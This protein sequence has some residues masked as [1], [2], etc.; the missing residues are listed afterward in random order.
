MDTCAELLFVRARVTAHSSSDTHF[1][2]TRL[3]NARGSRQ[4]NLRA[5][6]QQANVK[7]SE[8]CSLATSST[9]SLEPPQA[10][11]SDR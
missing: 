11:L 6:D 1:L 7:A 3:T 5:A 9:M 4:L 2:A 8:G 10:C